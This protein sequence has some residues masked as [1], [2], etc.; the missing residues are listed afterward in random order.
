MDDSPPLSVHRDGREL[1]RWAFAFFF[2]GVSG[3][4][5]WGA[6]I[7]IFAGRRIVWWDL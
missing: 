1:C 7:I 4:A 6:L 5:F 3:V 2:L